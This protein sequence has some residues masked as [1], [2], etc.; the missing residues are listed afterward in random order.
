MLQSHK[1]NAIAQQ[2][3]LNPP[4]YRWRPLELPQKR[5]GNE[6]NQ[7]IGLELRPAFFEINEVVLREFADRVF[8]HYRVRSVVVDDDVCYGDVTCFRGTSTKG[9]NF[10]IARIGGEVRLLVNRSE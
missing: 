3:F 7:L 4:F 6:D 2:L 1:S 10:M 5:A 8:E 9:E